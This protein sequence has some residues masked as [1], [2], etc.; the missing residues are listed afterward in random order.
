MYCKKCGA[1]INDE[2]LFCKKCG[3][4]QTD[5]LS[6]DE[7]EEKSDNEE[8]NKQEIRSNTYTN[9]T[10]AFIENE[11]SKDNHKAKIKKKWLLLIAIGVPLILIGIFLILWNTGIF[12][13][14]LSEADVR[15]AISNHMRDAHGVRIEE[16][17][18]IS[19]DKSGAQA[20]VIIVY[21]EEGYNVTYPPSTVLLNKQGDVIS[22][23][24]CQS[25]SE[26]D[27]T[28]SSEEFDDT[29]VGTFAT[30]NLTTAHYRHVVFHDD[31]KFEAY[32]GMSWA[33][34]PYWPNISISEQVP[35]LDS[36]T[37]I[38]SGDIITVNLHA[39]QAGNCT[40][41]F[42]QVKNTSGEPLLIIIDASHN[43]Y[44]CL[45]GESRTEEVGIGYVKVSNRY[46][47]T[48]LHSGLDTIPSEGTILQFS[49]NNNSVDDGANNS[50][51][52]STCP[53]CGRG[54]T[55]GNS[56]DCTWCDICN[57]WMGGHGHEEGEQP[58]DSNSSESRNDSNSAQNGTGST[59]DYDYSFEGNKITIMRY[60]G[61]G[62]AVVIPATINGKRV[63]K[64]GNGA[65]DTGI[66]DNI[67]SVIIPNGVTEIGQ[68]AFRFC[69]GLTS[70]TIPKSVTSIGDLAF[71]E[72]NISS[73]YFEGNAPTGTGFAFYNPNH[74]AT[75]YYKPG[76]TGWDNKIWSDFPKETW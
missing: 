23:I 48:T 74:G 71:D 72:T 38:V 45:D 69:H 12:R 8:M 33:D 20:T 51:S 57:A 43:N 53:R 52:S 21:D 67:K 15:T 5:I 61:S 9:E 39:D 54:I 49:D 35:C 28:S 65:F 7:M 6:T 11:P 68:R 10:T 17:I 75:I 56:C 70:I 13:S 55:Y 18:D 58:V 16:F 60:K 25:D 29:I 22:C 1:Q 27:E 62:G 37:Y 63:T 24:F 14:R 41:K 26:E 64:I 66:N 50:S 34:Y 32:T 46:L 30:N 3:A 44:H 59:A 42:Q 76:T 40:I 2:A 73:V 36:G 47:E 4:K 31:G 19:I